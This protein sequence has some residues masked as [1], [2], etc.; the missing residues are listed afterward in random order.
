[1]LQKHNI[2]IFLKDDCD[3]GDCDM[4]RHRI[5]LVDDILFKQRHRRIP[6]SM[7]EEVRNHIEMLLA[8]GIIRK[9]KSL[10]ASNAVLARKKNG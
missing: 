2:D 4:T 7:I 5:D 9:F 6:P 10:W 3:I 8:G 1:M